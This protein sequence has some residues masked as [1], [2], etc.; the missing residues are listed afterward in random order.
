MAALMAFFL[1]CA[2]VG[3]FRLGQRSCP[4]ERRE[5]GASDF[6]PLVPFM[7]RMR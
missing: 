3:L 2:L 6:L 7:S 1:E 5:A 4:A